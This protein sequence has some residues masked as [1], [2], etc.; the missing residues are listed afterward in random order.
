LAAELV[1]EKLT[2]SLGDELPY[3]LTVEIEQFKQEKDLLKIA[4]LIWVE[5]KSQKKIVIGEKGERLKS[6]GTRARL[7]MQKIFGSK[8]FL[9]LWV[10]VR[11]GWSD[12]DRAL[13]SLGYEE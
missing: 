9:Q 11:S 1:R 8:V 3:E 5:R 6:V 7:D 12:D 4:A 2:R 13:R 10:R